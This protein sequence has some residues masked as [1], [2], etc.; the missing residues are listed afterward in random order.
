MS[1]MT[2]RSRLTL[3][4]GGL[5]AA[6]L[7][8]FGALVYATFSRNLLHEID[9][10]LDEE[11]AELDKE[12][13][14]ASDSTDLEQ[15]LIRNFADHPF[16]EIQVVDAEG[17]TLFSTD[18]ARREPFP[19]PPVDG[20]ARDRRASTANDSGGWR[21]SSRNVP[22]PR[23]PVGILAADSLELYQR[24]VRWLL[25]I[26]AGALPLVLLIALAGGWLVSTRAL[27]PVDRMID[28]A[29]AITGTNLGHRIP[30]IN[31]D[32]ELGRLAATFND[33]FC[34][35]E[36]SFDEIR[37]FT[38]DAAHELRTPLAVLRCQA[39]VA[40]RTARTADDYRLALEN[41][42]EE[43]ERLTRL[44]EELLLLSREEARL[45]PPAQETLR[46][47]LLLHDVHDAMDV[48]AEARGV[49]LVAEN[50]AACSVRGDVDRLRR[51]FVNLID[52]A[53][54]ATDSGGQVKI[55]CRA[56][57]RRAEVE[58]RD[59]GV[60]I[61]AEHLPRVFQRFYRVDAARHSAT[62]G[63][64]LGLAIARALVEAHGGTIEMESELGV[65]TRVT[66]KLNCEPLVVNQPEGLTI[67]EAT[68]IP[69]LRRQGRVSVE[70]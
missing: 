53:I 23:G 45:S 18:G 69:G 62:G 39:E 10:A 33:M 4:Y 5:L 63:T 61:A 67:S 2:I 38:A 64:G 8:A 12:V 19:V 44:A 21:V 41:Q 32:D 31:R 50:I 59:T 60:G 7:V 46:L 65:G 55:R 54:N 48:A 56:S 28:T 70:Q 58:I 35:L 6:G 24:D 11:L 17:R 27:S 29:R 14:S 13:R 40:L 26:M 52:N 22:G 37:R 57:G 3:W 51:V 15:R 20:L 42:I 68:E 34:R 1:R 36:T 49:A 43:I 47:D 9:R 16:Y 25:A 66:V 30:I